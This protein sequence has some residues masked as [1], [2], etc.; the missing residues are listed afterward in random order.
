MIDI[1]DYHDDIDIDSA[2]DYDSDSDTY[3]TIYLI[4]F[5]LSISIYLIISLAPQ[6]NN[7]SNT[8]SMS[9]GIAGTCTVMFHFS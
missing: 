4:H 7:T 5:S 1:S 6:T 3:D 8:M 2:A 9:Y